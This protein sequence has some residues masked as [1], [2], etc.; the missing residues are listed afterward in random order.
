MPNEIS[1]ESLKYREK[2]VK[3][4]VEQT[5]LWAALLILVSIILIS[6]GAA[7]L[8]GN[9][10]L[11]TA[12]TSVGSAL[13]GIGCISLVFRSASSYLFQRELIKES[14]EHTIKRM[15][16]T[17]IPKLLIKDAKIVLTITENESNEYLFSWDSIPGDDNE[18]LKSFLRDDFDIDWAE[19][20]EIRKFDDGKTIRIY[21]DKK[22]AEIMIDEERGKAILK[23]CDGRT[24]VLK[25]K[26]DEN[27]TLNIYNDYAKMVI[28]EQRTL[29]NNL[30]RSISQRNVPTELPKGQTFKMIRSEVHFKEK[31]FTFTENDIDIDHTRITSEEGEVTGERYW[32][33]L[34][35]NTPLAQGEGITIRELYEW[36][37]C[38]AV[39]GTDES[40]EFS[41]YLPFPTEKL[42][43]EL[44]AEKGFYFKEVKK[45][46]IDWSGED[47]SV[48]TAPI[49]TPV[50][51][52][53]T[54]AHWV[55][56]MEE[57]SHQ[58]QYVLSFKLNKS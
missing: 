10:P 12:F 41:I 20:A 13:F 8:E 36:A 54:K 28:W 1:T 24:P 34:P 25:V 22:S 40:D 6:I 19:N 49:C 53:I 37:P 58:T 52:K 47:V 18:K 11:S 7:Y 33:T 15:Y 44:K 17:Y 35:F 39:P 50:D 43:F 2:I 42:Q 21:N 30:E 51:G 4:F 26:K 5:A 16:H 27:D 14:A 29:I 38:K 9:L 57:L 55:P 46:V 45:K 48:Q 3:S 56:K 23:I 31:K 32:Y